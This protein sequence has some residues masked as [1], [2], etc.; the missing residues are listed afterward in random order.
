M[1]QPIV[2]AVAGVAALAAIAFGASAIAGAS[3]TSS[4]A[5]GPM[6]AGGMP[7]PGAA[8]PGTAA[9]PGAAPRGMNGGPPPGGSGFGT[10]VT[11]ANAAKVKAAALAR[12]PGTVERIVAI[13]GGRYVAH[14]F[15]SGGG[16]E[17]HVLVSGGF[18]VIGLTPGPGAPGGPGGASPPRA[19]GS[20]S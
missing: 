8:A 18:Q 14:V 17:V 3:R 2:K 20:S 5:A 15:R 7:A 4:P 11:G 9:P 13:P 12:Y 6:A 1:S 16:G 10:P 19:G